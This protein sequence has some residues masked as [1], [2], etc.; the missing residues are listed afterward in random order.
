MAVTTSN[1]PKAY[2]LSMRMLLVSLT[3]ALLIACEAHSRVIGGNA[4]SVSVFHGGSHTQAFQVAEKHCGA[5]GKYARLI[6]TERWIMSFDCIE[7]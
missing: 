4:K 6:H 7:R 2:R 1:L 5:H 3:G